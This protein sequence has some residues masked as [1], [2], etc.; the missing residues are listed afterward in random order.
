VW[1]TYDDVPGW[2]FSLDEVSPDCYRVEGRDD[3]GRSVS[4]AGA[5]PDRL[6]EDAKAWACKNTEAV[7]SR[8]SD[9]RRR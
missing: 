2:K 7:P 6:L 5:D 3:V 1:K 8:A 4:L 9:A